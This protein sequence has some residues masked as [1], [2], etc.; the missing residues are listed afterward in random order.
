MTASSEN[1]PATSDS[2]PA[3]TAPATSATDSAVA[4]DKK[5][6]TR[7]SVI[8]EGLRESAI[9][10][11]QAV[12]VVAAVWVLLWVVGKLWVVLLPVLLAIIICTVLWP[13]VAL[14]RRKGV[15]PAAAALVMMLVAI[16]VVAAVIALIVP[17]VVAQAPE[18][19]NRA[20]DGVQRL[21]RWVQGPPLNVRDE[22]IDNAVH[23]IVSK[24]QSSSATIASGV[25]SGVGTATSVLVTLFTMIV[26]VFFFL[27]DGPK[28]TPWIDRTIGHPSATH[29]SEVLRRMWGTLGGFIRTQA[30][31]SLVDATF[32]GIGLF[33]LKVPLAGVLV[34]ITFMGGFIPIVGAFVAGALAVLIALVS[35]GLTTALIVLAII[36]AVQ[37][38]EGNVLQPW[39]QAKSM[40]LHA[41]IVLLAVTL[42]G[43][44]FGITGAFLAVPAAATFTV[45][46][47]YLNE[48]IA[49][50]AGE[51][52][53]PQG[54][55]VTE[56]VGVP[57]DKEPP[58]AGGG[59]AND[60]D[61]SP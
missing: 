43:S 49:E 42:G 51:T 48:R 26:L 12:L 23:A 10:A 36:I 38:L 46:L 13:P 8:R 35:N 56:N 58:D 21:Q 20:T 24:L 61:A 33:I 4:A 60:A 16:G 59:D 5:H 32:I 1:V 19:A 27:K 50:R 37:Q 52:L 41:V 47:R 34:V 54:A 9:V 55:P 25:F 31:V 7:M 17:S 11:L 30:I 2:E 45:V 29:I 22:Q 14:M 57:D 6:P 15:P 28:F 40:N 3:E 18:L 39:L 53:P 44:I